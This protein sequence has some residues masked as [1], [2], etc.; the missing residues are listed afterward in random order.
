MDREATDQKAIR[1]DGHIIYVFKCKSM[2]ITTLKVKI[3]TRI[4]KTA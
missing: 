2:A 3:K 4:N 1:Y